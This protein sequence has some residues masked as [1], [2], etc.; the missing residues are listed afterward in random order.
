MDLP[1]PGS[2]A[3]STTAP[4]TSPP[5]STRSSSETPVFRARA[6][7]TSTSAMGRAGADGAPA[8]ILA[9]AARG[10][11]ISSSVPHAWHSWQ[12]PYHL[13]DSLSALG[14]AVTGT[15]R[16][17]VLGHAHNLRAPTDK[18]AGGATPGASSGSARPVSGVSIGTLIV[19]WPALREHER[20]RDVP[21][22]R[23][24][25]GEP[26]EHDADRAD[27]LRRDLGRRRRRLD[28]VGRRLDPTRSRTRPSAPARR[29][30]CPTRWSTTP[31]RTG[32]G[33]RSDSAE[34]ARRLRHDD[35]QAAA[36]RQRRRGRPARPSRPRGWSPRSA[37]RSSR[38]C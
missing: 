10:T 12:R 11:P 29:R 4:G 30:R 9:N 14:T 32:L 16:S 13:A 27:V 20:D 38:R 33:A 35:R 2:P 24:V 21:A 8:A 15:L 7:S 23:Q 31:A 37:R 34:D 36:G 22:D 17:R 25:L 26:G 19:I 6:T 5:P 28:A 18:N 1:T 3:S